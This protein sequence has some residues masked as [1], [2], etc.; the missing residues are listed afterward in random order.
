[1]IGRLLT[2]ASRPWSGAILVVGLALWL[3]PVAP[4]R[5]ADRAGWMQEARWGVMTHYLAD[6]IAAEGRGQAMTVDS[7][8]ALVDSF[9][10]EGLA[11]QLAS[12]GAGYLILT[13]GQNSGFYLAPNPTYDRL[14][15]VTPSHC[16]RRDLVSDVAGALRRR[17]IRLIVYLPAGAPAQDR[18]AREALGW[19][20]GADRNLEFQRRW[21]AVI[22]DWSRRWGDVV[23]GWWFDGCYWPNTMYRAA[24]PPN[25]ASFA[26]AARAGNPQAALAFNPG[27]VDRILSIT[28][29]EDYTAGEINDPDR[30]MIRRASGGKVDGAQ[31]H[32]LTYLG[33]TWGRG[34]PRFTEAQLA[35][36]AGN[37][38]RSRGALTC[39]VPITT[40]GLIARPFLEQLATLRKTLS[41]QAQ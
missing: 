34:S 18:A 30:L 9:D 25:F 28:P 41:S 15:G 8:N 2:L 14:T 13:I 1:M 37:V 3:A 16:A 6:W 21:E 11:G 17:G 39:D 35:A 27:V 12:V 26:A 33:S 31:V 23:A 22:A 40:E 24:D 7:W 32:V 36:F 4:A 5:G 38:A 29:E 19:Q 20:N 10:V